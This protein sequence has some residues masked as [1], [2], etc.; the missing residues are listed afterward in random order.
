M[1]IEKLKA[2][3]VVVSPPLFAPGDLVFTLITLAEGKIFPSSTWI[4]ER[5]YRGFLPEFIFLPDVVLHHEHI[6]LPE[7]SAIDQGLMDSSIVKDLIKKGIL[8]PQRDVI[9]EDIWCCETQ[10]EYLMQLPEFSVID[11]RTALINIIMEPHR[12]K[13]WLQKHEITFYTDVR[14]FGKGFQEYIERGHSIQQL[15]N[16]D[17]KQIYD[18]FLRDPISYVGIISNGVAMALSSKISVIEPT[19]HLAKSHFLNTLI[20]QY[21]FNIFSEL[22]KEEY[23]KNAFHLALE[24]LE[25]VRKSIYEELLKE[26]IISKNIIY[27]VPFGLALILRDV[28]HP[29]D[30]FDVMLEKRKERSVRKFREWLKKYDEALKSGNLGEIAKITSE[31]KFAAQ[32]LRKEFMTFDMNKIVS[33]YSELINTFLWAIL[34]PKKLIERLI[35]LLG[36]KIS[37]WCYPHIY[38]MQE[39]GRAGIDIN[40]KKDLERVFGEQGSKFAN[41]LNYHSILMEKVN[42]IEKLPFS[43]WYTP[44]PTIAIT[45]PTN[46][47]IVQFTGSLIRGTSSITFNYSP[48]KIYVFV[49]SCAD[50]EWVVR[51][52]Q[53]AIIYPNGDWK[54]F[55]IFK[56][57]WEHQ[58]NYDGEQHFKICAVISTKNIKLLET[59]Q[60]YFYN[61]YNPDPGY[62]YFYNP[63]DIAIS[64][65][66]IISVTR[67]KDYNM[68]EGKKLYE[69]FCEEYVR[70][71]L[72]LL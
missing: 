69:N 27:K 46:G 42:D 68:E 56:H 59:E 1:E 12:Y 70:Y 7:A 60:D 36:E 35:S 23:H 19:W 16:L 58:G 25:G 66:E 29:T 48:L 63:D 41:L 34:S 30:F 4:K 14:A 43:P 26:G 9:T 15:Q 52:G 39:L 65:S 11:K 5:G 51:D 61:L 24:E 32:Q 33:G 13:D 50:N 44:K 21:G 10:E 2:G 8:Y 54:A 28:T 37:R 18:A 62:I 31:T 67:S 20:Q 22:T 40:V 3:S 38:Y 55:C 71:Q 17:V 6:I 47:S 49:Y 72:K 57:R 53:R 45:Y 64:K